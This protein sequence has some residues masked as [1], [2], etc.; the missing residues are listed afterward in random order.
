MKVRKIFT[1]KQIKSNPEIKKA[2]NYGWSKG[3]NVNEYIE[4]EPSDYLALINIIGD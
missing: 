2:I 3:Y 1:N 4:L